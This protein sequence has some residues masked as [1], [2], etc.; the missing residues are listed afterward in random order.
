MANR[1][2]EI[3]EA[4][5]DI[6]KLPEIVDAERRARCASSLFEWLT[7]YFPHSTGLKP[8]SDDH[9]RVINYIELCILE[10]GLYAQ[11]IYR[12][13]A[14]TTIGELSIL[15]AAMN[16]HRKYMVLFGWDK[17]AAAELI[18]DLQTEL[19][20]N[21]LLLDDFPEVCHPI[22]LINGC[23]QRARSQTYK[24]KKT[25]AVWKTD[26]LVLPTI[27]GSAASSVVIRARPQNNARGLRY[28]RPDG[29]KVRP[30][31]F[32]AD[33]IQNDISAASPSAVKKTLD[34][35]RK[36]WLFLAGHHGKLAGLINGT[37]IELDDVMH[38]LTDLENKE[39][40]AFQS[41][42]FK[43]VR[44]W[45]DAH[46]T[47][48]LDKY[49]EIRTTYN[50]D[51]PNDQKRA[52]GEAD[53]FYLKN[54]E[55]MDAGCV[56][57]WEHCYVDGTEYSAIQHAYN[58]LIDFG[59]AAFAAECQNEPLEETS[60]VLI[61]S[62]EAIQQKQS[63]YARGVVPSSVVRVTHYTDQQD[64]LLYWMVMGWA[65]DF[66]GYVL[67]YGTWP[68]QKRAYFTLADAR[69]TLRRKYQGRDPDGALFAGI[70]DL[71]TELMTR[72]FPR[73]GGG[74]MLIDR[75]GIDCNNG[76]KTTLIERA[77]EAS[78]YRSSWLAGHGR[79]V[80][81]QHK[82]ISQ[83][84]KEAGAERGL[85]W[86][87]NRSEGKRSVRK[88]HYD[89]WYWKKRAID[90]LALP[91]GSSGS[92]SLFKAAPEKHRL[93]ADHCRSNTATR[94][95]T[96]ERSVIEWIKKPNQEDHFFDCYVANFVI[97]STLGIRRQEEKPKTK[98]R[99]R[100]Q[101]ATAL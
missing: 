27:E 1:S 87:V 92:V 80:K 86:L 24:G 12:G 88:L 7:T 74:S 9:R 95:T 93:F 44:K 77:I 65:E 34:R 15:W 26:I 96:D 43:M 57:S 33:D 49:A 50:P 94:L 59:E 60:D 16:G 101:G 47:L 73:D 85:E 38:Q 75:G 13:F 6:G 68:D 11:A 48:W 90:A 36:S 99:R 84:K 19:L 35:I 10:G 79:G 45:A 78:P 18:E 71:E 14:K 67:D 5:G 62:A 54:R 69:R 41:Q 32:L 56:V 83:W 3:Y 17:P 64:N 25:G 42:R 51:D 4:A 39:F 97:A 28:T 55:A 53:A 29:T 63:G 40:A 98:R 22:R 76:P 52:H 70:N 37:V 30:D 23:P 89:T 82:P 91:T 72:Q 61:P 21:D 2:R 81:P 20:E 46:D 100:R 31:F 58:M 66:T 8:L